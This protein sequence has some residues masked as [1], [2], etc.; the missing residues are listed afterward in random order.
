MTTDAKHIRRLADDLGYWS[1]DTSGKLRL[2]KLIQNQH[3]YTRQAIASALK[4]SDKSGRP[5]HPRCPHCGRPVLS[6]VRGM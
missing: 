1:T 2:R 6:T 4:R 5:K 3:P